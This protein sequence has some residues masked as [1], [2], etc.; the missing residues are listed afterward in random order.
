MSREERAGRRDIV[1][2][3]A[4]QTRRFEGDRLD[5]PV[6]LLAALVKCG[7][8]LNQFVEHVRDR[9]YWQGEAIRSSDRRIVIQ[10]H[11]ARDGL[12]CVIQIGYAAYF[13]YPR[14]DLHLW[15][16]LLPATVMALCDVDAG[17]VFDEP[18]LRISGTRIRRLRNLNGND[19]DM[20]IGA[21][22]EMPTIRLWLPVR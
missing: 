17:A 11:L 10:A 3:H 13:H 15:H 12:R 21:T 14:C 1:R 18:F 8:P 7:V 5:L 6:I 4:A 9:P 22:L 20:G 19:P 16:I 2:H